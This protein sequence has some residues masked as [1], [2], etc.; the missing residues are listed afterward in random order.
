ME[1]VEGKDINEKGNNKQ[2]QASEKQ[3]REFGGTIRCEAGSREMKLEV[4]GGPECGRLKVTEAGFLS[5]SC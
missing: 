4:N 5:E 1:R 2:R 3:D